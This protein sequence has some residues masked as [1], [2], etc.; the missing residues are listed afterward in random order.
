MGINTN[1]KQLPY[2]LNN[3]VK[4]IDTDTS[5][6]LIESS[7][8][9][10]ALNLRIL[11][12]KGSNTGELHKIEGSQF[13]S[14][15]KTMYIGSN[16]STS[17]FTDWK[18]FKSLSIRNYGVLFIK[19]TTHWAIVRFKFENGSITQD[20]NPKV[21][22]QSNLIKGDQLLDET[23][24]VVANYENENTIKLYIAD[25][26]SYVHIINISPTQDTYNSKSSRKY[27]DYLSYSQV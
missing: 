12:N 2:A 27:S 20:G 18:V 7:K 23:I 4:G 6:Y 26:N 17:D 1:T 13:I 5:S 8:Y 15:L 25:G 14:D 3:F 24:S 9:R 19:N 10:D 16:T 11:T 22:F 21:I